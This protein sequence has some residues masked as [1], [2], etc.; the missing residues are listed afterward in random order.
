MTLRGFFLTKGKN[1]PKTQK[2]PT[3]QRV[4]EVRQG[5]CNS[6]M[7]VARLCKA[8]DP[9]LPLLLLQILVLKLLSFF[10]Q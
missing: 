2:K 7:M 3:S 5:M 9:L 1:P 10:I 8:K 6:K 4:K